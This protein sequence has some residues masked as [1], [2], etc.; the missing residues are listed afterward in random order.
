MH[1]RT[2]F[3]G[4]TQPD[5]RHAIA[6]GDRQK[7]TDDRREPRLPPQ[8]LSTG[9]YGPSTDNEVRQSRASQILKSQR[10]NMAKFTELIGL[11]LILLTMCFYG[12]GYVFVQ[13]LDSA[14]PDIELNGIRLIGKQNNV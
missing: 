4:Q 1:A 7:E 2:N 13:A 9:P 5:T 6:T 12:F 8:Y 10:E 11:C 3:P 14:I